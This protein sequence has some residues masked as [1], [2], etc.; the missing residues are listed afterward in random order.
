MELSEI[1]KGAFE[2]AFPGENFDFV[3]VVPAT[4]PKFGDYQCNDA[5]K[6][7][8]KFKMN[9]REVGTKV[10][11][12]LKGESVFE[13]VEIAGPGFLNLTV[14][15][16]WLNSQLSTSNLFAESRRE[17]RGRRSSSTIR[18]RMRRSRCTSGTSAR[19]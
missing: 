18:R 8:K 16:A 2:K 11:D 19:R 15:T 4:D 9:P 13:K 12:L 1:V 17:E 10:A 14:S 5:L 7:A 6:L 3:R